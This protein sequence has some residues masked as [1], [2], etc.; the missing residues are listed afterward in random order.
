M[1]SALSL[2]PP[3]TDLLPITGA[4]HELLTKS[5]RESLIEQVTSGFISNYSTYTH[6]KHAR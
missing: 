2:I 6:A 5:N 4:G 3:R 1:Q